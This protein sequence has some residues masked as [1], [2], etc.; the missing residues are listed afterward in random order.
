MRRVIG[1][2]LIVAAAALPLS[3]VLW[4]QPAEGSVGSGVGTAVMKCHHFKDAMIL[5]PGLSHTPTDQTV[6]AHG[7]VYGCNKAGGGG[8]YT[9]TLAMKGATCESRTYLGEAHF[10][11]A[12]GQTSVAAIG[13]LPAPVEPLKVEVVGRV[14]SGM[15]A[16]LLIHSFI[17]TK[18]VFKGHGPGCSST[19]LLKRVEFTNSQ[20]LQFF[21]PVVPTTTIPQNTSVPQQTT[22]PTSVS[23][24]T[25]GS[26]TPRS[27]VVQRVTIPVGSGGGG[28]TP[29]SGSGSPGSLALT[30]TGSRGALLGLESLLAGGAIWALGGRGRRH[31]PTK[32]GPKRRRGARPW[33]Y[34][35]KPD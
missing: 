18:D 24:V 26:T 20:S 23:V 33:L 32:R 34:V 9:A 15:F 19:N 16:G 11:W 35:I 14:K 27:V 30:G 6:A 1:R 5:S 25:Q 3:A 31:D 2:I 13:L 4:G 28:T 17:R 10:S 21:T 12:N 8:K 7:R 29:G 22:T